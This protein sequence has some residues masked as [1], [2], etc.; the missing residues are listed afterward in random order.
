MNV[1][2]LAKISLILA[3]MPLLQACQLP[4]LATG[5]YEQAKILNSRRPVKKVINDDGI[6]A[7]VKSK[8]EFSLVAQEF[9]S[10]NGLNCK[11]NFKSYV[12]LNRPYVTYL[13]IASR[14]DELKAKTWWFPIVGSF[15]YKGYFSKDKAIK[16]SKKLEQKDYDTYIRGVTAYSSL[17][18][19]KE[20]ILSSMLNGSKLD[21]A[22]TI[23]HECFHST[24]FYKNDVEKNERLAVFFAHKIM[25]RFLREQNLIDQIEEL[26]K[27]WKDQILFSNF[28]KDQIEVAEKKF[29]QNESQRLILESL[30]DTYLKSLK[31]QIKVL[32]FDSVF[33]RDLNN[34]KLV[35][36]KTYFHDF[37]SLELKLEQEFKGDIFSFLESL[38]K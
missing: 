16:A 28:L 17:G 37:Q 38:R 27:S 1:S 6:S 13:L 20:P 12:Q 25:L 9:A 5:A 30:Q 31:P 10:K 7:E 4:Y 33:L 23:F 19:F 29:E 34:A 24:I 36:F 18:W 32:N 8:L 14:K 3:L 2:T 22:D 21:L 35:A 15:P 11:G 26:K